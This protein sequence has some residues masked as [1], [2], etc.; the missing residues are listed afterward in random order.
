[1]AV[2]SAGGRELVECIRDKYEGGGLDRTSL[3]INVGGGAGFGTS[4]HEKKWEFVQMDKVHKAQSNIYALKCIVL[5][6]SGISRVSTAIDD[7]GAKPRKFHKCTELDLS[8]NAVSSWWRLAEILQLF[9][10][11]RTLRLRFA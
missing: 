1:M 6:Q 11:L 10:E 7:K 2:G 4:R 9:P 8:E 5:A 3:A